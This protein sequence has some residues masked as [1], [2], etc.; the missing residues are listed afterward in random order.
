MR[1]MNEALEAAQAYLERVYAHEPWSVVLRPE[2]SEDGPL[3]WTVRYDLQPPAGAAATPPPPTSPVLVPKD[4]SAV[5]FPPS[6]LPTDEYLAYVRHGGWETASLARTVKALPWQMALQWLLSTYGGLVELASVEPVAQ[7]AGTWL[8]ACRTTAQPGYPRTPM[9]AASLVVPKD[10]GEPFH[11]A[12]DDPWGDAAAYTRDGE[13][14]DPQ[15]QARRLNSRGCVV[16]VAAAIA[17]AP[18]TPLPW[19]PVHEAPGWWELLLRRHFPAAE[20]LRCASWDEVIRRAEE[21]GPD[22]QGVVWVRRAVGG[23]EAS[24]HLLYAHNNRGTVV[25]LDGMT[26]GL[27]RLD[28]AGLKELV[29]A[30]IRPGGGPERADDF[31]AARLKAEQWVGRTYAD[32]VELVAPDPG[33]ET[34]RGWLF[35]CQSSAALRG[36]DWRQAMLD[37]AVVVPKGPEEP[38]LLPNTDPWG[39]LAAWD[40]GEQAGPTPPAAP[41]AAWFDS[42]VQQLGRVLEVSEYATVTDSV[43]A[44]AALPPGGRALLWVRRRDA[45]GRESTGL[46]LTGLRTEAGRVGI[47]DPSAE[48]LSSLDT[49]R[50]CGVRVIR[51]R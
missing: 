24:G 19:Q 34:A 12:A 15:E 17:G 42:T 9:L 7:D 2:H 46:L 43:Q 31:A 30:R 6:H 36:G 49:F 26:G 4:G 35:A 50:E 18:S 33:D 3:A 41:R 8:F 16:T 45:R 10:L 22:T 40:R 28:T 20:Q 27:A 37:A 25:L 29:F 51:Y 21:T 32:P 48:E 11:P 13:E 5:R 23:V 1:T 14:R 47:L 39:Y 38:F 44:V